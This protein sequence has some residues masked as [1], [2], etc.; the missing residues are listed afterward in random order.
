MPVLFKKSQ[1]LISGILISAILLFNS[2]CQEK[3]DNHL[4]TTFLTLYLLDRYS[5][6]DPLYKYQW[7]L[8][9]TGQSGGVAGEDVNIEAA[10]NLGY[11]GEGV[12]ISI[13]DDGIDVDHSDLRANINN[14]L[15][16]NYLD[17]GN[18]DISE[19]EGYGSIHGTCVSGVAASVMDNGRGG[20]G[21]APDSQLIGYNLLMDYNAVNEADAMIRNKSDVYV[22]NNS[23]GPTDLTGQM[24]DSTT[25][26]RAAVDEAITLGR[27]G[28]GVSFFWA[29]GNGAAQYPGSAAEVDN[30]NYDGYANYYGVSAVCAVTDEGKRSH[31]SE[32]GANLWFCAPSSGGNAGITTTDASGWYGY[33]TGNYFSSFSGT[34]SASPLA[35]GVSALVLSVNRDL[36]W[37]DVRLIMAKSARRVDS[38]DG[39]WIQNGAGHYVNHKYGFGVVDAGAAVEMAS[40]WSPVGAMPSV[41][42]TSGVVDLS[43]PDNDTG[44]VSDVIA[45]S[46]SGISNIEYVEINVEIT[47]SDAGDLEIV[48]TSP[49]GTSS[50]LSE[51]HQCYNLYSLTN[52]TYF[53]TQNTWRFGSARHMDEVADGN[54]TIVVK[55]LESPDPGGTFHSW[56]IKIYGR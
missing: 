3:E 25:T 16:Y 27:N 24:E 2:G 45:I 9:N 31:Y 37:R 7:H 14:S 1:K 52:C 21:A 49:D 41:T 46:S 26:W 43:I 22:S 28:K 12:L 29:G 33:D 30:S 51:Q 34:S 6:G 32:K 13:V 36:G 4:F 8:N 20:I 44:G 56:G 40:T 18:T 19:L 48:L 47:H 5:H 54:W 10:W 50:V 15:G 55:D 42:G 17:P 23:W 53:A 11:S 39:D 38:S 35:A